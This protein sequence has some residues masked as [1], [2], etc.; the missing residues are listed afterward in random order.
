MEENKSQ[1]KPQTYYIDYLNTIPVSIIEAAFLK[2]NHY[3]ELPDSG[4]QI[5]YA[6]MAK[7][8]SS[9]CTNVIGQY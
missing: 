8:W 6:I 9:P 7:L 2:Q 5:G 3:N 1:G 4:K